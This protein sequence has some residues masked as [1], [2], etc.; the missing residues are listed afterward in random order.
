MSLTTQNAVL[1]D[2]VQR[3]SDG[4]TA[5]RVEMRRRDLPV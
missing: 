1:A 4:Y 3:Q 5:G 2:F